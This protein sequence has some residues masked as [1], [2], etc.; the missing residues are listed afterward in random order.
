M[1]A[2]AFANRINQRHRHQR[3]YGP[4]AKNDEMD[5][6][7]VYGNVCVDAGWIGFVLDG[8]KYIWYWPDVL[9]QE[10]K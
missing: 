2:T 5:A 7:V 1:V 10:T 6:A 3:C 9:Y 4:N 8:V